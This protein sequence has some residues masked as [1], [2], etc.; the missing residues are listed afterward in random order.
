MMNPYDSTHRP[1]PDRVWLAFA[2]RYARPAAT[3]ASWASTPLTPARQWLP[4]RPLL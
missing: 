2:S 3:A 1:A 4:M